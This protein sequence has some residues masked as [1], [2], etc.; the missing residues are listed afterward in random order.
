MGIPMRALLVSPSVLLLFATLA[1]AAS[2]IPTFDVTPSCRGAAMQAQP[3]G[4]VSVCVEKEQ[5]VRGELVQQWDKFLAADKA[6][7]LQL[8]TTAGQPTY[9]ELLT[10]LEMA[11]QVR[12]LHNQERSTTTGQGGKLR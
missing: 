9:T 1:L 4:D 7:C 12:D 5:S 3:I 6:H 8:S 11:S 2:D 10:C